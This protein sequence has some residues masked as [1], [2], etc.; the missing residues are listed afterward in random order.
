[1]HQPD[2]AI[3]AP[4]AAF[5][6]GCA[7]IDGALVPIAE[8]RI[9]L[10]DTG[11]T[12]SDC[13]YDV[14]AV[15]G[16]R[17]FRLDDHLARF[18]RSWRRGRFTPP[19]DRAAMRAVLHQC[20]R[21]SGLTEAYVEMVVTRG[22]PVAGERDPRR[23]ENRFY[24]FAIPYVWIVRPEQQD[25][26]IAMIIARD[27]VR[28]DPRAVDP[29]MKNFHWGDLVAGLFEAYDREAHNV[30]LLNA[31][32]E[33]TEGPGFNVFAVHAGTLWTPAAGVLEGITRRSV[34]ELAAR[35]G[36]ATEVSMSG[37]ARLHAADELF[38]TSTAGGIMPVTRLDGR[39]VGDGR[40]GPL[41]CALRSAYWDAHADPAWT[42]PVE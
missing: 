26:G 15:W 36:I 11:F 39:A 8:A 20:V 10:L 12:R 37:P 14:V 16:G 38:I 41:T 2:P 27:T 18:E 21:A 1:M 34:L 32:G 40:P 19:L 22:V 6:A 42:C 35:A 28:I 17:F 29:T 9:P 7:W 25:D 31:A 5:T 4:A 3:T 13:T 24:A 30:V 33:V 23:F